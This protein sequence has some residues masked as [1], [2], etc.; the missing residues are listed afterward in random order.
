[1]CE[2]SGQIRCCCIIA[3]N[4]LYILQFR[5]KYAI[6]L[7]VM[8]MTNGE[9]LRLQRKSCKL[10]M[11]E[12]SK[13]V[14]ITNTRLSHLEN[15]QTKEPSPTLLKAL[16]QIYQIDVF[17]LFSR[18]G[19]IDEHQHNSLTAFRRTELLTAEEVK[20]IQGQIDYY[21]FQRNKGGTRT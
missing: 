15:D 6:M 10:S 18:Y 14:N 11:A 2:K 3:A 9:F 5:S 21:I 17:E 16:A 19:Y 4:L 12:V 8:L 7:M 13:R 1:M 20:L